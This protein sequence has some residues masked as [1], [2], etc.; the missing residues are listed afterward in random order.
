MN[1]LGTVALTSCALG[2]W[3]CVVALSSKS[4]SRGS[5][6]AAGDSAAASGA[7]KAATADP[8]QT[9]AVTGEW[10]N[11]TGN[12]AGV[13]SECGNL[14]IVIAKPDE[15]M[16]L[17]GV[18]LRGLWTS[19]NGGSTWRQIGLDSPDRITNRIMSVVFDPANPQQFWESG[20]YNGGGVF[21]T[22]DAGATF[23]RLGTPLNADFL[24]VDF[25]DAKR[26]NLL[27]GSHEQERTLYYSNDGGEHWTNVGESLPEGSGFSNAPLILGATKFLVG[28]GT[29]IFRTDDAGGSWTLARGSAGVDMGALRIADNDIFWVT[30]RGALLRSSDEGASFSESVREGT[31]NDVTPVQLPDG[32]LA[33]LTRDAVVVSS[34][35][36]ET[37]T[38]VSPQLLYNDAA[39]IRFTYSAFRRAFY[40][41][42]FTCGSGDHQPVA[43]DAV[44]RFD[45]QE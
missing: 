17:A 29:G 24:S 35:L 16:L 14:G 36:G 42:H 4:E 3:S 23:T 25:T 38:V 31:L 43:D 19:T 40:L 39:Y 1:V 44:L 13:S 2:L 45:L 12:L 22:R 27:L 34:D 15:D 28:T 30:R 5:A 8:V 26:R 10:V 37:W 20:S 18:A 11:V 41:S 6:G 9:P 7:G 21:V 33:A 32:R